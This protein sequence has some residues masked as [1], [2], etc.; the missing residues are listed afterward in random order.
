MLELD[1]IHIQLRRLVIQSF[2]NGEIGFGLPSMIRF[3]LNIFE[4][5]PDLLIMFRCHP[6]SFRDLAI[7]LFFLYPLLSLNIVKFHF[8]TLFIL[9][10][11]QMMWEIVLQLHFLTRNSHLGLILKGILVLGEL[12]KA[13]KR[14]F[15]GIQTTQRDKGYLSLVLGCL[16]WAL[17]RDMMHLRCCG[18]CT[19][20]PLEWF[21]WFFILDESTTWLN[22]QTALLYLIYGKS[23][24]L[25][26]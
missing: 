8:G 12:F 19:Y 2:R 25:W 26:L 7:A 23:T 16:C 3:L 4:E 22:Q 1:A 5:Y 11:H 18:L 24:I 21:K 15:S 6:Y 14:F 20:L 13:F 17:T 10:L 9:C